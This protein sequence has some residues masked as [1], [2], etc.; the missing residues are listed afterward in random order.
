MTVE[1]VIYVFGQKLMTKESI[2]MV[3]GGTG[4][5]ER[6]WQGAGSVTRV[7]TW[8]VLGLLQKVG[9]IISYPFSDNKFIVKPANPASAWSTCCFGLLLSTS[10]HRRRKPVWGSA[11]LTFANHPVFFNLIYPL[12]YG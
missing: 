5:G 11:P 10:D 12:L 8:C 4:G 1:N 9:N 3:G 6:I 7:I 2:S